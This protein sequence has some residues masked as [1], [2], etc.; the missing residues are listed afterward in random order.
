MVGHVLSDKLCNIAKR[1]FAKI[2]FI[3]DL[4]RLVP[5]GSKN[6]FAASTLKSDTDTANA[7]KQVYEFELFAVSV[8]HGHLI[9][10]STPTCKAFA[11]FFKV[12]IVGLFCLPASIL[13]TVLFETSARR[14]SFSCDMSSFSLNFFT[15]LPILV[16]LDSAIID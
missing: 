3:H 1:F 5:L 8:C 16:L 2:C 12:S 9:K 15:V 6:A 7:R 14:A 13:T 10:S 11:T 4:A